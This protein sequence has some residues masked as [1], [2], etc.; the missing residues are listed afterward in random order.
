M[1]N[2]LFFNEQTL[3][4]LLALNSC[5][6]KC[7]ADANT[8]CLLQMRELKL[9]KT[10][11]SVQSKWHHGK[12][13]IFKR[14]KG[15]PPKSVRLLIIYYSP[16]SHI[17]KLIFFYTPLCLQIWEWPIRKCLRPLHWRKWD[18]RKKWKLGQKFNVKQR[19]DLTD[20]IY[21]IAEV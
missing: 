11:Q 19:S 15:W 18:P 21:W 8:I 5:G 13:F 1:V 3:S 7:E 12:E 2:R 6:K 14:W 20:L 4:N 10:Q 17:C 9:T 16:F